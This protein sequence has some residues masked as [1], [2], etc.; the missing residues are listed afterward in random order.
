MIPLARL[1]AFHLHALRRITILPSACAI[2]LV[3]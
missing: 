2:Q 1:A 3:S